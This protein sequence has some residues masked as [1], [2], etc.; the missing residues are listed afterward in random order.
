LALREPLNTEVPRRPVSIFFG[1]DRGRAF[2]LAF[3]VV[4]T[5]V[6]LMVP[7]SLLGRLALSFTFALTLIFGAFATI[8]RRAA[9]YLVI[10]LTASSFVV[11]LISEIGALRSQDSIRH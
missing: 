1:G 7:L 8:R 9:I 2:F 4:T 10:G 6:V 3:L 5:V 11:D